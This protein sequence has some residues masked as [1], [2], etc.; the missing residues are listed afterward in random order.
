MGRARRIVKGSFGAGKRKVNRSTLEL[1]LKSREEKAVYQQ[2]SA[3]IDAI[4]TDLQP[5]LEELLTEIMA[6]SGR[7]AVKNL[8]R[9]KAAG[10]LN[11]AADVSFKFDETN[12]EAVEWVKEHALEVIDGM[13]KYTR[14]QVRELLEDAFEGDY[15]VHELAD[16]IEDIIGDEDR[17]ET[18]ARTE[19]MR[20]S[21][22]GQQQAWNQAVDAGVLTGAE[23]KVWIVTPDD[24]LCPICEGMEDVTILMD[25]DFDVDGERVSTPPGHPRCRC[26][27][28]LVA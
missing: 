7:M 9:L 28:G 23:Q 25:E 24:R 15:D 19:T 11:T 6:V 2:V 17:A 18:I 13:D 12:P 8:K 22:E 14:E 5:K 1:A 3:A 21:N 10:A 20:A 4:G 16:E 27:I 26:T